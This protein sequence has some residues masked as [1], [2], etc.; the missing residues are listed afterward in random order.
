MTHF[1]LYSFCHLNHQDLQSPSF[2]PPASL[3]FYDPQINLYAYYLNLLCL[4]NYKW[5]SAWFYLFL[6]KFILLRMPSRSITHFKGSV[7]TQGTN[8]PLSFL[9]CLIAFIVNISHGL[10]RK[11]GSTWFLIDSITPSYIVLNYIPT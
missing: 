9:L 4:H 8:S 2:V 5:N 3:L 7:Q 1:L 11:K 6:Y 10:V